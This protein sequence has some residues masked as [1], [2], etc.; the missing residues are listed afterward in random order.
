MFTDHNDGLMYKAVAFAIFVVLVMLIVL[1]SIS[2]AR[3][4][5]DAIPTETSDSTPLHSVVPE[6]TSETAGSS[7]SAPPITDAPE[8]KA[9][10]TTTAKAPETTTAKAPE[11]TTAKAPTVTK[12]PE[13]SDP[14]DAPSVIISDDY[15]AFLA[16][17]PNTVLAKTEDAGKEYVD[18]LIFLGDSTTYGLRAYKMLA[19][20]KE[21]TQVWTPAS[22]TLT[23]SQASFA[24]IVYPETGEEITIKEAVKRKQPEYLVITLGVNGVS[25]MNEQFFKS[26]YKK[27]IETVQTESPDTKIICQSMFPVAKSYAYLGSINNE[28]IAAANRW[29]VEVADSCGVKFID[30]Y[31]VLVG[32]D[33][34]LPDR[35]HNGD[36]MHLNT[37]SFTLELNNIRTHALIDTKK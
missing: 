5:E 7:D 14:A 9:P 11:T 13:G 27:I 31:S 25:F 18:K 12:T 20:G 17:Y 3:D 10:E 1:I 24:T 33:G 4:A 21:T 26:E 16:K 2:S 34:W 36:G 28:K 8:T 35:Y 15:A 22:G 19:G 30:T 29:I 23:L 6:E 37:E 32:E